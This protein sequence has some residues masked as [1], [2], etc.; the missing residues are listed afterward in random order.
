MVSSE[1]TTS[2]GQSKSSQLL[3]PITSELETVRGAMAGMTDDASHAGQFLVDLMRKMDQQRRSTFINRATRLALDLVDAS[4]EEI[5]STP[6]EQSINIAP[7]AC[8]VPDISTFANNKVINIP[9]ASFGTLTQLKRYHQQQQIQHDYEMATNIAAGAPPAH[10][11]PLLKSF[12]HLQPPNVQP[13]FLHHSFSRSNSPSVG[14]P[15]STA[16]PSIIRRA[17]EIANTDDEII[18]PV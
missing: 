17:M 6:Y 12:A 14:P 16:T 4:Q 13:S 8:A 11:T 5:R 1:T 9:S 10:V 15:T 3:S 18:D 7:S 2:A